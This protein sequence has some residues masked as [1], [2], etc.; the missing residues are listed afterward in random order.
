MT[1]KELMHWLITV[2]LPV[3]LTLIGFY[4][5]NKSKAGAMEKRLTT[6]EVLIDMQSKILDSHDIRLC[7]H[8]EEQKITMSLV[9]QIKNLSTDIGELKQDFKDF[10]KNYGG[11]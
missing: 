3:S 4:T 7:K 2:V 6:M 5:T 11:K 9:E 8:E 10:Q 1:E